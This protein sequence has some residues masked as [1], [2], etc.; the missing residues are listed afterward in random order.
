MSVLF[1]LN[2]S[3]L[4]I[5]SDDIVYYFHKS[6][7]ND[8]AHNIIVYNLNTIFLFDVIRGNEYNNF[9]NT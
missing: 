5:C 8:E 1:I 9:S 7:S 3:Y 2:S 6:K 4:D